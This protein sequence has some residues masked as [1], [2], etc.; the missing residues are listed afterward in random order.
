MIEGEKRKLSLF[1]FGRLKEVE[2]KSSE[3]SNFKLINERYISEIKSDVYH[4]IHN[5]TKTPIIYISN[6]DNDKFMSISFNTPPEDDSG[7][8]HILEHLVLKKSKKYRTENLI[9]KVSEEALVNYAQAFTI[10]DKTVFPFST[11]NEKEFINVMDF[12]LDSVFNPAFYDEPELFR[13]EVWRYIYNVDE[14]ELKLNGVVLNEMLGYFANP[15]QLL[16]ILSANSLFPDTNLKYNFAGLPREIIKLSNQDIINYHKKHFHPSNSCIVIYGNGEISE[17]LK[18]IDENYLSKYEYLEPVKTILQNCRFTEPCIGRYKYNIDEYDERE[19]K[20]FYNI[21]FLL[22]NSDPIDIAG[23]KILKTILCDLPGS[24]VKKHFEEKY[25]ECSISAELDYF[26]VQPFFC[27]SVSG[28]NEGMHSEIYNLLITILEEAVRNGIN[29]E[30]IN[31][32]VHMFEFKQR[33]NHHNFFSKGTIYTLNITNRIFSGKS[34]MDILQYEGIIDTVKERMM[35]GFFE[36]LIKMHLLD[37]P[38][39]GVTS[40]E[41]DYDVDQKQNTEMK[42]YLEQTKNSFDK[43]KLLQF[44]S[45]YLSESDKKAETLSKLYKIDID[46][47]KYEEEIVFSESCINSINIKVSEHFTNKIVYAD[48]SFDI[49]DFSTDEMQRAVVLTEILG[50]SFNDNDPNCNLIYKLKN[51]TGYFECLVEPYENVK[52]NTVKVFFNVKTKFLYAETSQAIKAIADVL[53]EFEI[54]NTE[55]LK[56]SINKT[57]MQLNRIFLS[58]TYS[59][60]LTRAGSYINKFFHKRDIVA[61]ISLYRKLEQFSTEISDSKFVNI[62][63]TVMKKILCRNRLTTIVTTDSGTGKIVA[64][65]IAKTFSVFPVDDITSVKNDEFG[66]FHNEAFIVPSHVQDLSYCVALNLKDEETPGSI[67]LFNKIIRKLM[68]D[69]SRSEG[70]GYGAF[71]TINMNGD[72][73]ITSYRDPDFMRT[74]EKIEDLKKV[75]F[76]LGHNDDSLK[77]QKLNVLG[78]LNAPLSPD[79]FHNRNVRRVYGGYTYQYLTEITDSIKHADIDSISRIVEKFDSLSEKGMYCVFGDEKAFSG[80]TFMFQ[81]IE[82]LINR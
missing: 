58:N 43:S 72:F 64:E 37:N 41:P 61:N 7:K 81:S 39:A 44:S 23:F 53:S 40:T 68:F 13:K 6:D 50:K 78:K 1:F 9:A 57:E 8:S 66:R 33:E 69:Y 16:Y 27:V 15:E 80:K 17:H 5:V 70:G 35:S 71:S 12:Y 79:H 59:T 14:D 60:A 52:N 49:S 67:M 56:T 48:F 29:T 47:V 65:D 38:H 3:Y 18:F 26:S 75:F 51:S 46:D 82:R 63:K 22:K 30:L 77:S 10:N 62:F 36:D 74:I 20:S 34:P 24:L 19:N 76:S 4:F 45:E 25:P 55:M 2:V 11:S 31:S 73:F 54:S 32:A 42:V 28:L 21:N